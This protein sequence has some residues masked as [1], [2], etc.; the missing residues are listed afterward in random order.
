MLV[1]KK[2]GVLTTVI[3]GETFVTEVD[4]L[5]KVTLKPEYSTKVKDKEFLIAGEHVEWT[6][7]NELFQVVKLDLDFGGTYM[8]NESE[9]KTI[10]VK[11]APHDIQFK[12]R[13]LRYGVRIPVH[14]G[15]E[16]G[17]SITSKTKPWQKFYNY[18]WNRNKQLLSTETGKFLLLNQNLIPQTSYDGS[19]GEFNFLK[20]FLSARDISMMPIDP[21][22]T[23]TGQNQSMG[24]GQVVDLEKTGEVINKAQLANIIKQECYDSI[25][26]NPQ[27]LADISPYQS[28]KSVAAGNQVTVTQLQ[29][30]YSKH[31]DIMKAVRE[32]MIETALFLTSKGEM[33][34]L[35]YV[36]TDGQ[37][38]AFTL[39]TENTLMY[40]LGLFLSSDPADLI[41]LEII[42]QIAIQDNTMGSDAYE[43]MKIISSNTTTELAAFLKEN[44]LKRED[45]VNQQRKHEQDMLDKQ[46]AQ[47]NQDIEKKLRNDNEQAQLDREFKL[48][49][50]RIKALGY[51]NDS[52]DTISNEIKEMSE[53]KVNLNTRKNM[54]Q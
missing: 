25:G 6:Y 15:S 8:S 51:A 53:Y 2:V 3:N 46:I 40:D 34:D 42:K 21:S 45:Q 24:F 48:N 50:A 20:A 52:A 38:I 44:S 28:A 37:R 17:W 26:L 13:N 1:P 29:Y 22:L 47:Q 43:K 27:F 31:Y 14:G 5:F 23:N 41:N 7:I 19:W 12:H 16:L 4:E 10:W 54:I 35:N 39:S 32:T 30:L 18:I 11:L 36:Q 33:R 9:R 49:E